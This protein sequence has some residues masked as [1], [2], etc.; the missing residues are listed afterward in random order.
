MV[1]VTGSS[2]S[3]RIVSSL[4][5]NGVGPLGAKY[6]PGSDGSTISMNRSEVSPP[7]V[8]MPQAG[9]GCGPGGAAP[10]PGELRSPRPLHGRSSDLRSSF[11]ALPLAAPQCVPV[12]SCWRWESPPSPPLAL[13]LAAACC[14]LLGPRLG[15]FL[16]GGGVLAMVAHGPIHICSLARGAFIQVAP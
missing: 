11:F 5:R 13:L 1:M 10:P 2:S 9:D 16:F 14:W 15:L 8:V 3:T 12:G 6:R 7:V 4:V